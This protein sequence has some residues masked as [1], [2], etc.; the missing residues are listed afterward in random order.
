MMILCIRSFR[1]ITISHYIPF[2]NMINKILINT[3]NKFSTLYFT[4]LL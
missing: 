1:P 4:F 2:I 3:I